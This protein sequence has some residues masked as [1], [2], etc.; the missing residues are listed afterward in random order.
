MKKGDFKGQSLQSKCTEVSRPSR[1][2][3]Y[4]RYMTTT[5]YKWTFKKLGILQVRGRHSAGRAEIQPLVWNQNSAIQKF[6]DFFFSSFFIFIC[7]TFV[8]YKL[9]PQPKWFWRDNAMNFNIGVVNLKL[10]SFF[11][12]KN[13][14]FVIS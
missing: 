4:S 10:F 13:T 6:Q 8:G 9:D 14:F 2:K 3:L 5:T 1:A 11:I 7:S 12:S